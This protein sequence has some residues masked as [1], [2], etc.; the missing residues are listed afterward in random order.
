MV[1]G[2]TRRRGAVA[3]HTGSPG[4]GEESDMAIA[5]TCR[6]ASG[7]ITTGVTNLTIT[8]PML[9]PITILYLAAVV[10]IVSGPIVVVDIVRRWNDRPHRG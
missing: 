8:A 9:D 5:R 2:G 3:V 6:P 7:V 10:T 1:G 4:G